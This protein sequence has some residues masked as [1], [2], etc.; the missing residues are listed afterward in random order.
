MKSVAKKEVKIRSV[1]ML[2]ELCK[3]ASLK[4]WLYKGYW[5]KNFLNTGV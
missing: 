2:E 3:I 1:K 4:I 5:N